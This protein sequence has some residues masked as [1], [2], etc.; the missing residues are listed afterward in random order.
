[1]DPAT[2]EQLQVNTPTDRVGVSYRFDKYELFPDAEQLRKKGMQVQLGPKPFRL[3]LLLVSKAGSIVT[4]EEIQKELWG[5]E[6][7]VDFEQ[8]INAVIRRIRFALNDQAETPRFL[9]TLPRR[10]YSFLMP[11]ERID[12]SGRAEEVTPSV[13]PELVKL[14]PA[15]PTERSRSYRRIVLALAVV[16]ALFF[17]THSTH[18][19]PVVATDDSVLR[20]AVSPVIIDGAASDLDHRGLSAELRR[21]L[22][23][24]PPDKMRVVVPGS[25][26][27]LRIDTIMRKANE[28]PS[29]DARLVDLSSGRTLWSE[30]LH[31]TGEP[32]DFSL[33]VAIRVTRNLLHLYVPRPKREVPV[34]SRVSPQALA[35]YRAALEARNGSVPQTDFKRAIELLEQAVAQE[36]AFAEAWAAMGDIWTTRTIVW[37]GES[38]Q[39]AIENARRTLDRAIAVDPRS[40]EALNN[41]AVLL[42]NFDHSYGGAETALRA[43]LAADPSYFDAR[44]NLALLLCAMGRHEASL[45]EMQRAQFLDPS[46]LLPNPALAFLYLMARRNGDASAEYRALLASHRQPTMAHW[47]MASA[48]ISAGRW[49]DAAQSL[50]AVLGERI[51]IPRDSADPREEIRKH[52]RVLDERLPALKHTRLDPYTLAALHAQTG[53]TD[54]A[55]AALD[56]AAALELGDTMFT[57][58]DPRLDSIREDPRFVELLVR[59]GLIR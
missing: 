23:R 41:R 17:P 38:R 43:A 51:E 2:P 9:Q 24:I 45:S 35:L 28:G 6:T 4:R 36:P 7:F 12:P 48:A 57:Y 25:P 16:A 53:D 50:S 44:F 30:T 29:V 59:F 5:D 58:V 31:R 47:G 32:K 39:M 34:R 3:L 26:A 14:T 8:G 49:D 33:E 42:M 37:K 10:G 20:I 55:F 13:V 40:A 19:M 52:I 18:Q 15:S 56:R 54:L 21:Y 46:T 22:A 11:V 1:L 27:D